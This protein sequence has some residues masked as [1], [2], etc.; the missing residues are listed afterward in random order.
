MFGGRNVTA[1]WGLS[2]SC[3][4]LCAEEGVVRRASRGEVQKVMGSASH[5]GGCDG[6]TRAETLRVGLRI[7]AD[8][9]LEG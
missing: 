5:G 8:G 7:L 2:S 9:T 6:G 3:D 1:E 4:P